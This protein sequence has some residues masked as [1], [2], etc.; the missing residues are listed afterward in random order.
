MSDKENGSCYS[1]VYFIPGTTY[2]KVVGFTTAEEGQ[3]YVSGYE[4]IK[5]ESA[6]INNKYGPG[7]NNVPAAATLWNA[8]LDGPVAAFVQQ[9]GTRR[10]PRDIRWAVNDVEKN[11]GRLLTSFGDDEGAAENFNPLFHL[12]ACGE[13]HIRLA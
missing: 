6:R 4:F 11:T 3:Q 2:G 7:R 1:L 5:F 10:V 8:W 9:Y 13:M 12:E